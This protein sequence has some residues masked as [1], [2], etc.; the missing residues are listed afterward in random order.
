MSS[1]NLGV[2]QA[3]LVSATSMREHQTVEQIALFDSTGTP[4]V[5]PAVAQTGNTV[6]MTGYTSHAVGSVA[7]GD[8]VDVAVA[9]LE[10]RIAAL[11]A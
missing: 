11:E 8:T 6:L 9:K 10:A 3:Q 7:A 2:T 5:L 4:V 1:P